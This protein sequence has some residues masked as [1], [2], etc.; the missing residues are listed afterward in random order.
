M[1]CLYPVQH[2]ICH[3]RT[4]S[5]HP[6]AA[7]RKHGEVDWKWNWEQY[8]IYETGDGDGNNTILF[9]GLGL[10]ICICDWESGEN[11]QLRE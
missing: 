7:D 2:K 9:E 11:T 6:V 1:T 10:Q 4:Q 5:L 3:S 8:S